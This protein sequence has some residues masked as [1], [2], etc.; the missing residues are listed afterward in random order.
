MRR[1]RAPKPCKA[2]PNE[3]DKLSKRYA[4]LMLAAMTELNELFRSVVLWGV[5]AYEAAPA[6]V[7][8]AVALILLA[9]IAWQA[10]RRAP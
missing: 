10:K 5:Q 8:I 9:P 3:K 6:L 1:N 7:L 4:A 2:G